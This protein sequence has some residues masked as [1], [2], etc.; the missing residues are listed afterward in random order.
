MKFEEFVMTTHDILDS[1]KYL[2][3]SLEQSESEYKVIADFDELDLL[4]LN[5]PK[6]WDSEEYKT[7]LENYLKYI[8][9]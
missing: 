5:V 3:L 6:T 1:Y 2:K 7:Y 9:L 4:R 8:D